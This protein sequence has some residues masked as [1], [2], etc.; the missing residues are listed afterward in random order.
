M[1]NV[2]SLTVE[3]ETG[4]LFINIRQAIP[5]KRSLEEMGH[6]QPPT[7]NQTVNIIALSFVTKSLNP[8][9]ARS[10]DMKY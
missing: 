7:P 9:A 6:K 3:A 8:K 10:I 1:K 2:M 5:A 4:T